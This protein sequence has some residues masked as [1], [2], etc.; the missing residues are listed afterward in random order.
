MKIWVVFFL[1]T[2]LNERK[3]NKNRVLFLFKFIMM[4]ITN[5][6]TKIIKDYS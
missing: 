5:K 1:K 2:S 6:K 4:N 3:I